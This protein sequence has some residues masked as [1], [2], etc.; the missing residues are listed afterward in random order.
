NMARPFIHYLTAHFPSDPGQLALG[1]QFRE[2]RLIIGVR[3]RS[4][5]Q[6]IAQAEA[7]VVSAHDF[8]NLSELRVEET[9]LVMCK[10][11]FSHYG[12]AARNNPGDSPGSQGH[13]PQ[14]HSSVNRE[15]IHALQ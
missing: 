9:L 8:A 5:P 7:H 13:V 12:A 4:W 15:V 6:T 10:A 1:P 14:Q 2:L 3:D 11:P